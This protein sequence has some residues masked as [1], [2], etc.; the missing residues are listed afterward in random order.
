MERVIATQ[1]VGFD[2]LP[3]SSRF[4]TGPDLWV[5]APLL[6]DNLTRG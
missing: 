4:E 1:A 6:F 5:R 2:L 3:A